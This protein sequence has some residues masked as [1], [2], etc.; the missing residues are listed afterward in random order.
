MTSGAHDFITPL[1]FSTLSRNPVF[2]AF[3]NGIDGTWNNH[4]DLGLWADLFLIAPASANTISKFANGNCDNLLVACYLSA[5]CPVYIAP[6]MDLDM[7]K[8]ASTKSNLEKVIS[9]GNKIIGPANGELASGLSGEGRMTEPVEI[10]AYIIKECNNRQSLRKKKILITAGPTQEAIDPVRFISNHSSGK[11]GFA[12]AEEV[13]NRGGEIT[14]ISGPGVLKPIHNKIR[15]IKVVSADEMYKACLREFGKSDITIMAAAVADF[16]PLAKAPV[17]IKKDKSASSIEL[18]PTIDILAEMGKRK[19]KNQMLVGFALETN[20]ELANAEKKLKN[21]NLDFIVLN[22]MRDKGAGFNSDTNKIT[23][24]EKNNRATGFDLKSKRETAVDIVNKIVQFVMKKNKTLLTLTLSFLLFS[25]FISAQ[26]LNCQVNVLTP[27]IQSSDK[28]IY[29]TL[30]TAITEFMNNTKWTSDKYLNQERIECNIQITISER[31]SNDQF[32]ASIQVQSNRPILKTSYSSPVFN[33]KDDDF[34]FKYLEYDNL[35]YNQS[36]TNPNLIAV[37][38]FYANIILGIDYDTFSPMAGG[39][40]FQK[41]QGIVANS[42]SVPETGW[43][44]FESTR[45]R[46]W[47]A[48][49]FNNPIFKPIRQLYYDYHRRGLDIMS[50][51]KDDAI[52][53]IADGIKNLEQ[54]HRDK[55]GSFLMQV[56]FTSKADEVV[57]IFSQSFPDVK[58]RIVNTLNEIDPANGSKYQ[59]IMKN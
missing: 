47:L 25:Q 9:Y 12:I 32:K 35:E 59:Q 14:L 4:V 10:V 26:E 52:N 56:F 11:M 30:Q 16:T 13:A 40:Y 20:D 28:R 46:Y 54:V 15:H 43:K 18:K 21:K 55:P 44:A 5:K 51:K 50:E 33:F 41:A 42:Q 53:N 36:G 57:N 27:Q 38:A 24:I 48:E 2:T 45:N 17:K 8:H 19:K 3:K 23:I 31:V 49:N 58:S 37:L 34:D 39:I 7:F 29:T 6:A 1:T 22:S